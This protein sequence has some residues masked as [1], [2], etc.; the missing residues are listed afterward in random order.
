VQTFAP[1]LEELGRRMLAHDPGFARPLERTERGMRKAVAKLAARYGRA[2]A[3][4]DRTTVE[5]VERLQALLLPDGAPQERVH[6]LPAYACRF[7]TQG[8]KRQVL[9]ALEPLDW[10]R[11]GGLEELRP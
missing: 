4:T 5:R 7:G 10:S 11:L 8:F 6:A 1:E 3:R 9:A 2:L